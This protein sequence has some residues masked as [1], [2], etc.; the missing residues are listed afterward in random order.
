MSYGLY[1]KA[2]LESS[3]HIL[4]FNYYWS[5]CWMGNFIRT[6]K[7]KN[8]K[9]SIE[10]IYK[11]NFG[12]FHFSTQN[13]WFVEILK[14]F[15]TVPISYYNRVAANWK[16]SL[17]FLRGC[18]CRKILIM[19]YFSA[20]IRQQ[21]RRRQWIRKLLCQRFTTHPVQHSAIFVAWIKVAISWQKCV[22]M[23]D[24]E[25]SWTWE[26][27]IYLYCYFFLLKYFLFHHY[28]TAVLN[29]KL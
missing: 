5:L 17:K 13:S 16:F 21:W 4:H 20:Q 14:S 26:F 9:F 24:D 12:I 19:W 23:K 11:L 6:R 28:P 27:I 1:Q 22:A 10:H 7:L 18:L 29:L 15:E 2:L 8:P 25:L 3:R